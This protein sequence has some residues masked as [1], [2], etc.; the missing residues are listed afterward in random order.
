VSL[1]TLGAALAVC[2]ALAAVKAAG[3]A[4][5]GLRLARGPA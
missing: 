3:T 4:S 1:A 5:R 2:L